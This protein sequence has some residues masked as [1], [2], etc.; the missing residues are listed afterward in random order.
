MS[1]S[2]HYALLGVARNASA[3]SIKA[4]YYRQLR[5]HHPDT[6][7]AQL[8]RAE[9]QGDAVAI[10]A[11]Q[12]ALD[13][14]EH[15][16]Q[17]LNK[18]YD[19]LSDEDKRRAYDLTLPTN[20]SPRNPNPRTSYPKSVNT[21]KP[22]QRKPPTAH[23]I[24]AS[25]AL[26]FFYM[27]LVLILPSPSPSRFERRQTASANPQHPQNIQRTSIALAT[28]GFSYDEVESTALIRLTE[29]AATQAPYLPLIATAEHL[30]WREQDYAAAYD[31][32]T[33]SIGLNPTSPIIYFAR[34]R[35]G[36]LIG[37]QAALEQ[38][39]QDFVAALDLRLD[40]VYAYS[41]LANARYL[42]WQLT[43]DPTLP[44][45]IRQG[46]SDYQK[47]GGVVTP[48]MDIMLNSLP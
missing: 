11:A 15:I 44:D 8:H 43:D 22:T 24:V 4:A 16:T 25:V 1:Q 37:T 2:D 10:Q 23:V 29:R 21:T 30:Q 40:D 27:L 3:A 20:E 33:Q 19:V 18:A 9:E 45:L 26:V 36:V 46:I 48:K 17:G 14:A 12:R 13:K 34:A 5:Q 7:M 35:V 6:L 28:Q 47:N 31:L 32:Y 41:E 42:L 39:I 38:A